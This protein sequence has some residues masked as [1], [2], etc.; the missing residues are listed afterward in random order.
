MTK[1]GTAMRAVLYKPVQ[2]RLF[3]MCLLCFFLLPVLAG[4]GDSAKEGANAIKGE[5]RTTQTDFPVPSA[6]GD[7]TKE[8]KN[9]KI[10]ASHTDEGYIMISYSGDADAARVQITD[11]SDT[12]YSY[13]LT[14]GDM[15]TFPLSGGSGSYKIDVLEHA[16]DDMYALACSW[17]TDVRISDEF[18]PFL[19]PNL[20]CW[21]T[22]DSKA[23]QYGIQ[24]SDESSNDL[25][26]VEK[27]YNYVTTSIIYDT[28]L[29]ENVMLL[30]PF[31]ADATDEKTQ[32]FVKKYK[33]KFGETPNQFAADTYD[34]V[35]A[36]YEACKAKG[37]KASDKAA[38][39]CEAL[40]AHFT[41]SSFKFDGLTGTGMTWKNTGEVSK[42]PKGMVIKKG[43]YEGMD[44]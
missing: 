27:V 34:C 40:T 8:E 41:D 16:Y 32:N 25:D 3:I 11:P 4:C 10:D 37:V 35:Y 24:L 6:D 43:A 29:A 42:S 38:D 23:V 17:T 36:L 5:H 21:Y 33:E 9:V 15:A 20:Y 13:A 31:T 28:K 19:Y 26:Y 44:K 22:K 1:G 14:V 12:V 18:K 30:T 2:A 7:V 39:I